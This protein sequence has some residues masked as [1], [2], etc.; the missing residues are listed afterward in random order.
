MEILGATLRVCVDDLETAVPFYER[1]A[2]GR[3]LRFERGGVSVAAVGCF[4]LMS[5]PE[6][7]LDVLRKVAA[8][9]AVKDVEETGRVLTGL[10]ARVVA[11]PVETPA[12]RNLIAVH[13]D[14]SV[15]EYADRNG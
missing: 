15:Y 1:L 14:G 9:I 12:G 3:A 11:G 10:G 4:L 8:T 6:S 2:G 7:E 13:P 5:G